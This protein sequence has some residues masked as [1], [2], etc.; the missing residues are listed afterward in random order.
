[1]MAVLALK[2]WFVKTC[3]LNLLWQICYSAS[4]EL[5][6]VVYVAQSSITNDA[7]YKKDTVI[8]F[9]KLSVECMMSEEVVHWWSH[10]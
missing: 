9:T 3:K 4:I 6:R 5:T 7:L 2:L 10:D 1:M 8:K